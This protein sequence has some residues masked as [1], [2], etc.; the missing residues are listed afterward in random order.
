MY[1]TWPAAGLDH[2]PTTNQTLLVIPGAGLSECTIPAL[3]QVSII[4][5]QQTRPGHTMQGCLRIYLYIKQFMRN[6]EI[7]RGIG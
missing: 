3:R 4:S 6:N 2:K 5:P 7:E 1:H